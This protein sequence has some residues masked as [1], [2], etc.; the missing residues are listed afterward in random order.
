MG[1]HSVVKWHEVAQAA[2]GVVCVRDMTAKK[3]C[4]YVFVH[5]LARLLVCMC[6]FMRPCAFEWFGMRASGPESEGEKKVRKGSGG[7]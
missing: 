3:R 5:A 4:K 1:N 2:L 7:G 6:V